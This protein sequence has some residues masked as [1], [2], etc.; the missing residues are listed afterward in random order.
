MLMSLPGHRFTYADYCL[1][2]EEKRY[3]LVEGDLLLTPAPNVRH[4]MI[5]AAL[6]AR[7]YV[8]A[9][10]H[11]LGWVLAAPTDVILSDENVVQPDILFVAANRVGIMKPTGG[12]HGAP[13]LVV[14]ILS[15]S[16]PARDR[17]LKRKLY[18]KYGVREYWIIDPQGQTVEVLTQTGSG[19]QTQQVFPMGSSIES[20][21]LPGFTLDVAYLFRD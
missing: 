12:V 15:P 2:P 14:E 10:S 20:P 6:L 1:L 21:L 13:D 18:S 4:Q 19:L 11:G 8:F 16:N 9:D 17:V 5:V 3:E 7:M